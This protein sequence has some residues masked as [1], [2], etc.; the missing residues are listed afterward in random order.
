MAPSNLY[1]VTVLPSP[2][3]D[4]PLPLGDGVGNGDRRLKF[5]VRYEILIPDI[6]LPPNFEDELIVIF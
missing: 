6:V 4:A 1:F 5:Y 3:L 2:S